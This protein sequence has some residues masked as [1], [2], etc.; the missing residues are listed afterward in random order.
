MSKWDLP[1]QMPGG[2]LMPYMS[3]VARSNMMDAVFYH[4]GGFA[5]LV[6]WTEKNDENYKEFIK[7]WAKGAIRATQ[8][9]NMT[10][11][12]AVEDLLAR[13]DAGEHAKVISEP[14][15]EFEAA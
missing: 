5:R 15:T 10:P 1:T 8:V 7:L 2:D 13:L 6:A 4:V 11:P 12:T 9:Q 3:A 14:E